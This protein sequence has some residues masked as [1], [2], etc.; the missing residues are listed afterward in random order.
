MEV[1]PA[2]GTGVSMISVL[3]YLIVDVGS[4]CSTLRMQAAARKEI[5]NR[6]HGRKNRRW[7]PGDCGRILLPGSVAED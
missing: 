7:R 1:T 6:K 4:L 5:G 2:K 3:K